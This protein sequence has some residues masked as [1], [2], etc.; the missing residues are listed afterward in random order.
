MAEHRESLVLYLNISTH[1]SDFSN[2]ESGDC[3]R[4]ILDSHSLGVVSYRHMVETAERHFE[5]S[6]INSRHYGI[7]N[8]TCR[9]AVGH[10]FKL[11]TSNMHLN[12]FCIWW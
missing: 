8:V 6:G 4:P 12:S 9:K 3:C 2:K 1:E 5:L 7:S 11:L 10:S